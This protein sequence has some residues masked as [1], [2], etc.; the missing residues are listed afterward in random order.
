MWEGGRWGFIN[1]KGEAVIKPTF[2]SVGD[3]DNGLAVAV[4]KD[5]TNVQI[6]KKGQ[7]VKVLPDG[8]SIPHQE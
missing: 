2:I 3:F 4:T 5:R 6:N 1:K 8:K 7:I